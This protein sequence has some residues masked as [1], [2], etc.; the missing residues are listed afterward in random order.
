MRSRRCWPL[1]LVFPLLVLLGLSPFVRGAF[2]RNL[3]WLSLQRAVLGRAGPGEAHL[4]KAG[5]R[6]AQAAHILPGDSLALDGLGLVYLHY[7]D[8]DTAADLF[9]Q[10]PAGSLWNDAARLHLLIAQTQ[11]FETEAGAV[12]GS[13]ARS[14]CNPAGLMEQLRLFTEQTR[15]DLAYEWQAWMESRCALPLSTRAQMMVALGHCYVEKGDWLPGLSFLERAVELAP[16]DVE[17]W[18]ALGDAWL[19]GQDTMRALRAFQAAQQLDPTSQAVRSRLQK[20][21]E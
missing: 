5:E 12:V 10:V 8:A 9:A 19:V 15:C 1:F 4:Q 3:A 2:V 16:H 6:F 17:A 13:V 7:G 21:Q 14:W 20:L 18:L 11:A